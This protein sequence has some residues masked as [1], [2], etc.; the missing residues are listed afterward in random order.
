MLILAGVTIATL[1]GENGILTQTTKAK[2]ESEKA[3]IIEQIQLDIADKQIE[4]QGNINEDEFY[5]ILRKYGTISADESTLTTTK[6]NYEILIADI[7][8][9]EITS[10]LVTTPL[11]S[12]EYT[13]YND[14]VILDKYIGSDKEIKIPSTFTIDE[15]TYATGLSNS[16]YTSAEVKNGPFIGNTLIEIVRFD[17]GID[18][19]YKHT[20]IFLMP[21]NDIEVKC[22]SNSLFR[23]NK[24]NQSIKKCM[25]RK[26]NI[27]K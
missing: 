15:D 3:E 12:W 16:S 11:S 5:E 26:L 22:W 20:P 23:T 27:L 9:G 25:N 21:G 4:K 10:S 18:F 17:D 6:G 7:Y 24:N 19:Y 1:T 14:V 2:E 13:I 8:G